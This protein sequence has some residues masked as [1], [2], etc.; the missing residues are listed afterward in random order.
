MIWYVVLERLYGMVLIMKKERAAQTNMIHNLKEKRELLVL[1]IMALI[2]FGFGTYKLLEVGQPLA[3]GDEFGYW[4][5]SCFFVGQNWSGT[6]NTISYYSYGYSL[7]LVPIKL[8]S[9]LLEWNHR[10]MFQ[11]AVV[12]H[13]FML[14]G[15]LFLARKLCIRYMSDLHWFVR[16]MAC[17]TVMLYP[18]YIVYSHLT[19]TEVALAFLFWVYFYTLMRVTDHPTLANHIG[20]AALSFYMYIVHQRCL[21]IMIAS[22]MIVVYMKL[23]KVNSL[24]H[25]AAFFSVMCVINFVH[26]AIKATLQNDL[27]LANERASRKDII[28]YALNGK[29]LI[30]VFAAAVC[31][32]VLYLVDKGM[33]RFVVIIGA[34][35]VIVLCIYLKANIVTIQKI[36]QTADDRVSTNDFSGQVSKVLDLFTMQGG[37]RLLISI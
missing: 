25:V 7:L 5:N 6:T 20:F 3:Y 8:V 36:A 35:A 2:I 11:T 27:Y 13:A 4:S 19:L 31:L 22:I 33:G 16:D 26:S 23:L 1:A 15:G 37:L 30:I 9:R 18:S 17:L 28:G 29:T 10:Q 14:V 34:A 32:L 12:M 21:G 24:Y